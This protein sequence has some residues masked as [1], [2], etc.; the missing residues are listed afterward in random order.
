MNMAP[1]LSS[2]V[3]PASRILIVD[4]R[5]EN[6]FVLEELL[7]GMNVDVV[8]ALSGTEAL[9]ILIKDFRFLLNPDGCSDAGA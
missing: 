6:L 1:A 5:E 4:D 9:H 8:K 3:Q 7:S 2:K